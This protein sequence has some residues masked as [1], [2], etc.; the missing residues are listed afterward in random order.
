MEGKKEEARYT[1]V[2]LPTPLF[3]KI[4]ER[5]EGTGFTSV[6][7]YVVYVLR[8]VLS[9]EAEEKSEPFTREDE[10]RVKDRLRALGYLD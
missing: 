9:K 5:I 7:S 6:S 2:S 4:K 10:E 8:E 3:E 1:S